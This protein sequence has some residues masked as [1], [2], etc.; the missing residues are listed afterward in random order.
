MIS[1]RDLHLF[2]TKIPLLSDYIISL[3]Q[4]RPVLVLSFWRCGSSWVGAV[5]GRAETAHYLSEPVCKSLH[6][7]SHR[8]FAE[9]DE[10]IATTIKDVFTKAPRLGPPWLPF[11]SSWRIDRVPRG[12]LVI[13]EIVLLF[14]AELLRCQPRVILL[15]RHPVA[16]AKSFLASG[17]FGPGRQKLVL[18]APYGDRLDQSTPLTLAVSLYGYFLTRALAALDGY[19]DCL[20]ISFEEMC[21]DPVAGFK[22]IFSFA[23]LPFTDSSVKMIRRLSSKDEPSRKSICRKSSDMPGRQLQGI[24]ALEISQLREVW[25][26]FDLPWYRGDKDWVVTTEESSTHKPDQLSGSDISAL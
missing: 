1:K 3:R 9:C 7:T 25:E 14:T 11:P 17:I 15:R 19:K 2:W 4:S 24:S 6:S 8:L 10:Q 20:R 13:K 21:S 26:R 22:D 16:V 12:T 23:K 18:L 5:V